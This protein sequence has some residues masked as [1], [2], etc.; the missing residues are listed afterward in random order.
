MRLVQL[1]NGS[2]VNWKRSKMWRKKKTH[3]AQQKR[4]TIVISQKRFGNKSVFF[5]PWNC[6]KSSLIKSETVT[7]QSCY[8]FESHRFFLSCVENRLGSRIII[9]QKKSLYFFFEKETLRFTPFQ[10]IYIYNKLLFYVKY[11]KWKWFRCFFV[12]GKAYGKCSLDVTRVN[13]KSNFW[14]WICRK[15]V[16]LCFAN[17]SLRRKRTNHNDGRIYCHIFFIFY[18]STLIQIIAHK[19]TSNCVHGMEL[20]FGAEEKKN[21]WRRWFTFTQSDLWLLTERKRVLTVKKRQKHTNK[22]RVFRDEKH[23]AHMF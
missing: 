9:P 17:A 5:S 16:Y 2:V 12:W 3:L 11:L 18:L 22:K 7:L 13:I 4:L 19:K 23:S 21:N 1:C 10:N 20:D 15:C 14:R 8:H 6:W